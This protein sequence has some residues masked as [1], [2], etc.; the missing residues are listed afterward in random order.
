MTFLLQNHISIFSFFLPLHGAD[1][2]VPELGVVVVIVVSLS[3]FFQ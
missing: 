1:A 3:M 2:P